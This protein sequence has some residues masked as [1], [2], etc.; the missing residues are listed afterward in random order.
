MKGLHVKKILREKGISIAHYARMLGIS[1]QNLSAALSKDDI[2][3]GLLESIAEA[4]GTNVPYFYG[5]DSSGISASTSGDSSMTVAG[6][7]IYIH[8]SIA[9]FPSRFFVDAFSLSFRR[10][11]APELY[12]FPA[13]C[14]E[15]ADTVLISLIKI[16][17]F[18]SMVQKVA[19]E[20][21]KVVYFVSC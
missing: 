20:L 6:N 15:E 9:P 12:D 18:L 5:V 7:V 3:T 19:L 11:E 1:Q 4:I 2:R 16:P 17:V 13:S 10:F 21:L 8:I 14:V